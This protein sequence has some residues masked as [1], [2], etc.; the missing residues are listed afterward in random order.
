MVKTHINPKGIN[1]GGFPQ[2]HVAVDGDNMAVHNVGS[3]EIDG[4]TWGCAVE[5]F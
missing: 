4:Q 5:C 2:N 1:R 3:P